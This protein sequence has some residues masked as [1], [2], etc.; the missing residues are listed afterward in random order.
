MQYW[1]RTQDWLLQYSSVI[2]AVDTNR[3]IAQVD[4]YTAFRIDVPGA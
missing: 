4:R 2:S 3:E 1:E